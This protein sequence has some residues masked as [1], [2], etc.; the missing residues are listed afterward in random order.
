M[1]NVVKF[2]LD[3][4][5]PVPRNDFRDIPCSYIFV[6]ALAFILLMILA[7]RWRMIRAIIGKD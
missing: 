2:R 7:I 1:R 5:L 6:G 3:Y 4:R